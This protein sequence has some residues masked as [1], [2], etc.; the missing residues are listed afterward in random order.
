MAKKKNPVVHKPAIKKHV[1]PA[2]TS[3]SMQPSLTEL[4]P[5]ALR[6]PE[7]RYTPFVYKAIQ[8]IVASQPQEIG[9]LGLVETKD[10]GYL[11]TDLYIPE[12]TVSAAETDIDQDAMA[13][14][15]IEIDEAGLDPSKLL[16]W[17][18]SHVNMAVSPSHQDEEQVAAFIENA[19][20]F[21][22]GIYNKHGDAKVDVYDKTQNVIFQCVR[23]CVDSP[24]LTKEEI[25]QLDTLCKNNLKK[26]VYRHVPATRNFLPKKQ[27]TLLSGMYEDDDINDPFYVRGGFHDF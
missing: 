1:A 23:D 7:V 11:V 22:R 10:Y 8:H 13:A 14:L 9:W 12:Q 3:S 19:S 2:V 27:S 26:P 5:T 18:H 20:L 6:A 4:Y 25:K 21:I 17:G 16:Y 24:D 15:A